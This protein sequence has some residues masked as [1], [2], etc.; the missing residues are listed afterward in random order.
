LKPVN[1]RFEEKFIP[2]PNSGC[3]IWVAASFKNGY[4]AFRIGGKRPY[5][6]CAH[7]ASW[8]IFHGEIPHGMDVCHR[9]DSPWCVNPDHLF[10]GS[11]SEN[12]ADAK[13]KGRI[14][15]FLRID[16]KRNKRFLFDDVQVHMIR[17]RALAGVSL[18]EVARENNC[19]K[20]TIRRIIRRERYKLA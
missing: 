9:C 7:R 5:E 3:W 19:S 1:E 11:R 14:G 2:E 13:N 12:F 6:H 10:L 4:G 15:G 18:S 20:T 17:L 8:R 16:G